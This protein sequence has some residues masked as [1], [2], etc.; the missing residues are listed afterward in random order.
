MCVS[1]NIEYMCVLFTLQSVDEVADLL[2]TPLGRSEERGHA[3]FRG[4]GWLGC[5]P[6]PPPAG[7][8]PQ[9][10]SHGNRRIL[11]LL[12]LVVMAMGTPEVARLV[13]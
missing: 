10:G 4:H 8:S 13:T 7:A 3:G 2:H 1:V 6:L 9:P 12:V 11:L 5:P